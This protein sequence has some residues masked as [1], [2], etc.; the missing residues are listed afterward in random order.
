MLF[1]SIFPIW[2]ADMPAIVKGFLDKVLLRTFAY[3]E[4]RVVHV[5][6]PGQLRQRSS[7]ALLFVDV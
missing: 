4:N 2:W 5:A 7:G 1:R 6:D 3:M